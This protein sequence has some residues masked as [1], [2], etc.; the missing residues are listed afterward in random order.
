MRPRT[1]SAGKP[2]TPISSPER[3]TRLVV[4]SSA[5]PRKPLTSPAAS[6]PGAR[7][8]SGAGVASAPGGVQRPGQGADAGRERRTPRQRPAVVGDLAVLERH[9]VAEALTEA[10]A[11]AV[12]LALEIAAGVKHD[13]HARILDRKS[14]V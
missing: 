5:R 3:M 14:V 8:L 7:G 2:K 9:R 12:R 6:Q 11:G 13:L 4:L 10:H 1:R